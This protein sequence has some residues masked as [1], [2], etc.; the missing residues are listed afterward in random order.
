MAGTKRNIVLR[1]KR[2]CNEYKNE[3]MKCINK[4]I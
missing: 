3:L 4:W 2:T 1:K